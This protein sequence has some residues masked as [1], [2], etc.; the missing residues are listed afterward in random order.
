MIR[1]VELFTKK[2]QDAPGLES[3]GAIYQDTE[4]G[5]GKPR[6]GVYPAPGKSEHPKVLQWIG[7]VAAVLSAGTAATDYFE[8]LIDRANGITWDV[9]E[10]RQ[11]KS[12]PQIRLSGA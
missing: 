11:A 8:Y 5:P 7:T 1:Y 9:S 10:L 12:L 6:L 2:D 3:I 4:P